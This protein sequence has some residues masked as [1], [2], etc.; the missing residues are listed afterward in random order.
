MSGSEPPVQGPGDPLERVFNR[1]GRRSAPDVTLQRVFAR[2][3]A[4]RS[5]RYVA[6]VLGAAVVLLL[7]ALG[8][9]RPAPAP[10]HWDVEVVDVE[11]DG[12]LWPEVPGTH[13]G[14]AAEEM[15]RP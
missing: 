13:F 3:H 9:E 14:R 4:R 11:S 1:L 2:M 6:A 8:R 7:V 5:V 10:V 12:L 15:E